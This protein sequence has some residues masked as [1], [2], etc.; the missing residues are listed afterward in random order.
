MRYIQKRKHQDPQ[1]QPLLKQHSNPPTDSQSV[2]KHW[3][4]LNNKQAILTVLIDEQYGLCC[5]GEIRADIY[6]WDYHIEHVENKSQNP[7]R[8]F[9]YTNLL[10]SAFHSDKLGLSSDVFGG[11]ATGKKSSS[12]PI[13]MALFISPLEKDCANFFLYTSDGK[14]NPHPNLDDNNKQRASYT[15]NILNLNSAELVTRREQ[16]WIDLEDFFDKNVLSDQDLDVEWGKEAQIQLSFDS[17]GKLDSFFSLKRQ[18]FNT[19]NDTAEIV[20]QK[21]NNGELL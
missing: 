20:L 19:F 21:Y 10:A 1:L 2:R 12:Q 16:L 5:Y 8:T 7:A 9:D 14:I 15:I 4:K 13:D 3:K 18:F 6:G 11:H 17:D